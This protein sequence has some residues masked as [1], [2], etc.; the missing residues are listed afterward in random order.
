MAVKK[1][2]RPGGRAPLLARI[3]SRRRLRSV[4][5]LWEGVGLVP[6]PGFSAEL[7]SESETG[8]EVRDGD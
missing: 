2:N 1:F 5:E 4:K 7:L 8:E 6:G 3:E